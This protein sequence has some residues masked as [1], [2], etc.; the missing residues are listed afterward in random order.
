[1]ENQYLEKQMMQLQFSFS[2]L[3]GAIMLQWKLIKLDNG[4]SVH[5]TD[6]S[7]TCSQNTV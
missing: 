2:F 6:S 1:M 5:T 3:D 4:I 7:F